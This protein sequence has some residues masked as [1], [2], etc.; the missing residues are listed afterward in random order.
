MATGKLI[1]KYRKL[2]GLTQSKLGEKIGLDDSRVRQYE[3]GRRN[4]REVILRSFS[5][6]FQVNTSY[7]EDDLY[8]YNID[9]VMRFLFKMEDTLVVGISEIEISHDIYP[10][11][12]KK[13]MITFEGELG[14]VLD[15]LLASWKK[16]QIELGKSKITKVEYELWKGDYPDSLL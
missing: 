5:D 11:K 3:S 2:Y 15:S 6:V 14:T 10:C 4:P 9:D 8:P 13:M 1:K 7:L 12:I 16:K